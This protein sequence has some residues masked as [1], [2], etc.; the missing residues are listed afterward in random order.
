MEGREVSYRLEP[1][2]MIAGKLRNRVQLLLPDASVSRIHARLVEKEGR[3][4]LMD[5][6]SANGTYINGIRL[7]QNESMVL[8]KGDEIRFGDM[9]FQYE[10]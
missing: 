6:N 5:L 9:I 2:P 7:E 4:A 10:E 3:V 8:E 1:L